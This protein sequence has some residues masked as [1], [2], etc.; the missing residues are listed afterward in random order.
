MSSNDHFENNFTVPASAAISLGRV[1]LLRVTI[2]TSAS[3][4]STS[5]ILLREKE[6]VDQEEEAA[7]LVVEVDVGAR[8][9]V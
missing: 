5:D 7:T 1:E 9:F 6:D 4:A 3:P 2:S 8:P